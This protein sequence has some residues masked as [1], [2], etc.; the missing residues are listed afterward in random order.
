[1]TRRSSPAGEPHHSAT[2]KQHHP[3]DTSGPPLGAATFAARWEQL[4]AD[5]FNE[6]AEVAGQLLTGD[7]TPGAVLDVAELIRRYELDLTTSLERSVRLS[8]A[9]AIEVTQLGGDGDA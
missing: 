4:L 7:P 1:M 8:L 3:E 6:V 5:I 2:A 9:I